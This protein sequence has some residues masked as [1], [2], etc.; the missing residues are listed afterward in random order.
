MSTNNLRKNK[1]KFHLLH[2]AR[3]LKLMRRVGIFSGVYLIP[4]IAVSKTYVYIW[5]P[6]SSLLLLLYRAASNNKDMYVQKIEQRKSGVRGEVLAC[7]NRGDGQEVQ[8][9]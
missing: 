8:E 2:I 1:N 4:G 9:G 3:T 7:V 5:I 6:S